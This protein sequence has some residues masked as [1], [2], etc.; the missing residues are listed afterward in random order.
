MPKGHKVTKRGSKPSRE[1]SSFKANEPYRDRGPL[2]HSNVDHHGSQRLDKLLELHTALSMSLS[3][4]PS[5]GNFKPFQCQGS[6]QSS[7]T[8]FFL[9]LASGCP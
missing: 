3:L 4:R 6:W 8:H 5:S 2:T 1:A 9:E 7:E